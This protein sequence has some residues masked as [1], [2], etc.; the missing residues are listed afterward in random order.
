MELAVNP[1]R[2]PSEAVVTAVP[3][4]TSWIGPARRAHHTCIFAIV[5][6]TVGEHPMTSTDTPATSA[7]RPYEDIRKAWKAAKLQPLWENPLAHKD[8]EGGP[9]RLGDP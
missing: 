1:G 5:L 9:R 2:G 6:G 8:R 4:E 3:L 7:G